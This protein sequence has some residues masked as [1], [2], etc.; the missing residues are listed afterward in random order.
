MK[1]A[2]RCLGCEKVVKFHGSFSIKLTERM[3]NPLT[4]DIRETEV[5]GKLCRK[6]A[7]EAGY[8]VKGT[9]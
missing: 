2:T 1:I 9:E 3:K 7:A 8:K 4:G 5:K 6:C